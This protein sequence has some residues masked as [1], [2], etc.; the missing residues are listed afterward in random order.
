MKRTFAYTCL[1]FLLSNAIHAQSTASS[2]ALAGLE[3]A[4]L[5]VSSQLDSLPSFAVFRP[6]LLAGGKVMKGVEIL[7]RV[8]I[9]FG[10]SRD[11]NIERSWGW[12]VDVKLLLSDFL[13]LKDDWTRKNVEYYVTGKLNFHR[14]RL[15]KF[16][17]PEDLREGS[18][19]DIRVGAGLGLRVV[20]PLWVRANLHYFTNELDFKDSG[21]LNSLSIVFKF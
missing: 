8:H 15:A 11:V 18:S 16:G 1:F 4:F 10:N 19:T 9:I 12:G 3:P 20:S 21:M 13:K 17:I 6:T 2:Y 5:I 7:G 14:Y